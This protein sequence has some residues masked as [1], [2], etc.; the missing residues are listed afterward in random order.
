MGQATVELSSVVKL[1]CPDVSLGIH[2]FP[3]LLDCLR[4]SCFAQGHALS[5]R[6]LYIQWLLDQEGI[7]NSSIGPKA[8]NSESHH[9]PQR[10]AKALVLIALR[11]NYLSTI[12]LPS[13]P[14]P[15]LRT[16]P[17]KLP[18]CKSSFG[19]CFPKE[20]NLK[21]EAYLWT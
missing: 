17:N 3:E 4:Q 6:M 13:L 21:Q 9:I 19:V 18:L 20:P 10:L 8:D 12:V 7:K 15:K 2:S 16:L 14:L 5:Q 11:G 1:W